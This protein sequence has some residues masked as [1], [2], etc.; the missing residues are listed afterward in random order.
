MPSFSKLQRTG[1]GLD[2]LDDPSSRKPHISFGFLPILYHAFFEQPI[3]ECHFNNE[4]RRFAAK[5]FNLVRGYGPRRIAG[6]PPLAG[7]KK[8]LPPAVIKILDN[9]L[10]AAELG[11]ALGKP[12][13]LFGNSSSGASRCS[14][15]PAEAQA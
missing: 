13:M 14:C 6:K 9:P 4:S 15:S 12:R 8:I 11:D 2:E 1:N 5:V 3:F 7:L 10:T